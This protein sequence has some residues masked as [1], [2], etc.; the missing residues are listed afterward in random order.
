MVH[1]RHLCGLCRSES[2]TE[3]DRVNKPCRMSTH[4]MTQP[5]QSFECAGLQRRGPELKVLWRVS[6]QALRQ[7]LDA[8]PLDHSTKSCHPNGSI[9]WVGSLPWLRPRRTASPSAW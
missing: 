5:C 9:P 6:A 2:L 4:L 1:G 3:Q 7:H 8:A